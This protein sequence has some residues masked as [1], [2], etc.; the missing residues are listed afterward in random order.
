MKPII[1]ENAVPEL[2]FERFQHQLMSFDTEWHYL[3]SSAYRTVNDTPSFTH[4]ALFD[5]V[6]TSDLLYLY[7]SVL[8]C[9]LSRANIQPRSLIRLRCG[10]FMK[11]AV[12]N[13]HVPHI[14][15]DYPHMSAVYYL[16]ETDG[17]TIFYKEKFVNMGMNALDYFEMQLNKQV[18]EDFRVTP[19]P[20][21]MVIFDGL[22]Y[23]SSSSPTKD[24][25]LVANFNFTV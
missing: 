18:T 11:D 9:G 2:L 20:N 23:H 3:Q 10:M 7:E 8:L 4:T 17:D 14:D 13:I 15:Y 24:R 5:G 25:R 6:K 12:S 16:N 19:K 1:I 21:T 22:T